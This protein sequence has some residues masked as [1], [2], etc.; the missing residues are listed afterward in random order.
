MVYLLLSC[1]LLDKET[2]SKGGGGG[3]GGEGKKGE[4]DGNHRYAEFPMGFSHSILYLSPHILQAIR[5]IPW[6]HACM[7]HHRHSG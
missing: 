7:A 1:M 5:Y 2:E 4:G 6:L 3:G